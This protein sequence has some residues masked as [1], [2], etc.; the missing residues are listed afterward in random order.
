MGLAV[1]MMNDIIPNHTPNDMNDMNLLP[2]TT[3][4]NHTPNDMDLIQNTTRPINHHVKQ[5]NNVLPPP[6]N[7]I[8]R[9]SISSEPPQQSK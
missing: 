1:F 4:P 6:I 3:T 8:P 9:F 2:N 7:N 5:E